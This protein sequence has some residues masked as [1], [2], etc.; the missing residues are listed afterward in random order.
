M[1]EKIKITFSRGKAFVTEKGPG[2]R[3]AVRVQKLDANQ[4]LTVLFL[5]ECMN[6]GFSLYEAWNEIDVAAITIFALG[7]IP[8]EDEWYELTAAQYLQFYAKAPEQRSDDRIYMLLPKNP[9]NMSSSR[10]VGVIT[11]TQ[12]NWI[13]KA[14]KVM[15]QYC[16]DFKKTFHTTHEELLWLTTVMPVEFSQGTK[17]RRD[18]LHTV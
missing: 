12:F 7:H 8:E 11:E 16:H 10:E 18:L 17:A 14:K 6:A 5:E 3:P 2:G 1:T 9:V 15:N 13:H 4:K